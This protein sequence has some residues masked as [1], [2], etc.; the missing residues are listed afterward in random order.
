MR[1][2]QA[3]PPVFLIPIGFY[4]MNERVSPR[5]IV[6]TLMALAG[7]AVFFLV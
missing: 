1:V 4:F 5:A 2:L 3:L 6:G 7:V